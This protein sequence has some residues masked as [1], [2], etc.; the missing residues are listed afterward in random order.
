MYLNV[1]HVSEAPLNISSS[2][3]LLSPHHQRVNAAASVSFKYQNEKTHLERLYQ[4]GSAKVLFPK[5]HDAPYEAVLINTA[6][7]LTGGDR[8][9]WTLTTRPRS[10]V[11][12]TTQACEKAYRS[13]GGAAH[14]NTMI[15]MEADSVL[16]WLPQETILYDGSALKRRFEVEL[17]KFATLLAVECVQLGREA[18]NETINHLDFHDRWRIWRD[19]SLIFADDMRLSA[20]ENSCAKFGSNKAVA[21]LLFV[22]PMDQEQQDALVSKLRH[23]CKAPLSGFSL[24]EGKITGR[25]LALNSY[26]LRKALVPVLKEIR[27]CDLPR[28]WRI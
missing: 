16:H 7:G 9:Q 28:V 22:A 17:H 11:V 18:M 14:L 4:Q 21:S 13:S 19:G 10:D 1:M 25:I 23:R 3:A 15:K 12:V 5:H 2:P 27:G 26:E 20:R 8:L 24:V 6:G